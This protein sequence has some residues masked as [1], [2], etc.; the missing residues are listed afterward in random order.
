MGDFEDLDGK[1]VAGLR[2]VDGDGA[3]ERVDLAAVDGEELF[4]GRAGADLRAA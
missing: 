4:D 1:G 2:A 3:G